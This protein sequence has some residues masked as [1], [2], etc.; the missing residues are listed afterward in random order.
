MTPSL[1]ISTGLQPG[2]PV[3][4]EPSR[5]NGLAPA[6]GLKPLK[7]FHPRP[8]PPTRLKPGAN[9]KNNWL[10]RCPAAC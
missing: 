3:G 6:S 5:F 10:A 9:E 2:V 4:E 8:S 7:R 1:L